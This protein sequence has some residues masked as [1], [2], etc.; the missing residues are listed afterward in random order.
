MHTKV[1]I[2]IMVFVIHRFVRMEGRIKGETETHRFVRMKGGY[3]KGGTQTHRFVL[4]EG[5][6]KRGT[7]TQGFGRIGGGGG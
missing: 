1:R 6:I 4:M 3:S 5:R 2:R 7:Q